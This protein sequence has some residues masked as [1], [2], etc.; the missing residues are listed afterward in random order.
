MELTAYGSH[1]GAITAGSAVASAIAPPSDVEGDIVTVTPPSMPGASGRGL[2][3]QGMPWRR[4]LTTTPGRLRAASAILVVGLLVFAAVTTLATEA[5]SRAAGAVETKSAP[6][7]VAA[8]NLYA[9]LA[10]ADATASTIFLRA[11]L[12]PHELRTRYL[13]DVQQAGQHL[14]E[15]SRTLYASSA[16][17]GAIGTI[18]EQLPAYTGLVE[19]ARANNAQGYPVGAAYL[20]K[21]STTMRNE[22][23]PAATNLYRDAALHLNDN[24]Q[25]GTSSLTLGAVVAAG[26][27]MLALLI[28][29]QV[30]VR[31]RANRLLNVGLVGATVLVIGLFGWTLVRFSSAHDAL[32]RA[33]QRGSDSVEVLSSARILAL[34]AQNDENLAL[35]ERGT[36]D[37]YV[38]EF[39]RLVRQ[40][41]G[42]DGTG[43]LLGYAAGLADRTGDGT[44]VRSLA[45]PLATLQKV[46]DEV[47]KRD[48]DGKYN[49]AVGLSVGTSRADVQS[50]LASV[51]GAGQELQAADRF[52]HDLRADITRARARLATA[53]HDARAGFG[54]LEVAVPLLAILAG[55][56]VL[57]G[58]ERRIGEYR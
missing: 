38:A 28:A 12:E 15:V 23:L 35:I 31:R 58:L 16:A 43:G 40:L 48:D 3:V 10:D 26:L 56:L 21:A 30:F 39:D 1:D 52:Q 13:D 41:G 34:R 11:G 37:V 47:R 46:H 14:A 32:S 7:L 57:L 24:Y 22:I 36:G 49:E 29:V 8:E 19:A 9:S 27:A 53:A 45:T 17:Q 25:S 18:S 50:T 42:R 55:L 44:R 54:V 5:R 51:G 6:E 4:W 33:Q 2:R 20:R